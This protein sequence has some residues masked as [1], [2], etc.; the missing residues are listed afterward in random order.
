MQTN[1]RVNQV[2]SPQALLAT[3]T[4][5]A[6][7]VQSTTVVDATVSHFLYTTKGFEPEGTALGLHIFN[8][9]ALASGNNKLHPHF[10]FNAIVSILNT[11]DP[12]GYI[13][14]KAT[15]EVSYFTSPS[16]RRLLSFDTVMYPPAAAETRR[17]L[18][19]P[20]GG[21]QSATLRSETVQFSDRPAHQGRIAKEEQTFSAR[22]FYSVLAVAI[23][24]F[25]VSNFFVWKTYIKRARAAPISV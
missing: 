1:T 24:G 3:A 4:I 13:R 10:D 12:K 11:I 8:D 14:V 15:V 19:A 9:S 17:L 2:E 18:Q 7:S 22:A 25:F 5:T 21:S 20:V 6:L 23:V 16:G